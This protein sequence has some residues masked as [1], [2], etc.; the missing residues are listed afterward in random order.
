MD[1]AERLGQTLILTTNLSEKYMKLEEIREKLFSNSLS[2]V[3][4]ESKMI[5]DIW[6]VTLEGRYYALYHN[7]GIEY[8]P[9]LDMEDLL[10]GKPLFYHYR[11]IAWSVQ[12]LFSRKINPK[13]KSLCRF[14][15]KANNS[16]CGKWIRSRALQMDEPIIAVRFCYEFDK[17]ILA[18]LGFGMD[19]FLDKK[20][21]LALIKNGRLSEDDGF[22]GKIDYRLYNPKSSIKN[23]CKSAKDTNA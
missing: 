20:D 1:R 8:I 4:Q 15:L 7:L 12:V 18:L 19:V 6:N 5:Y 2:V 16:L 9:F 17:Y 13:K 10:S 3:G 23:I 22:G 14:L 21:I 11:N